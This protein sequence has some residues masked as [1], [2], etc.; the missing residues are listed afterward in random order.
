MQRFR[1]ASKHQ[2]ATASSR[3]DLLGD[4]LLSLL[5]LTGLVDTPVQAEQPP[6]KHEGIPSSPPVRQGCAPPRAAG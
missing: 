1:E 4:W 2:V 3:L 5:H 6:E